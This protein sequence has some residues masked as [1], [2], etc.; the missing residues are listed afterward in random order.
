MS[1]L[2]YTGFSN[3]AP[4]STKR[5]QPVIIS[6]TKRKR[7]VTARNLLARTSRSTSSPSKMVLSFAQFTSLCA[8]PSSA[9]KDDL[10]RHALRA[11][12]ETLVEKKNE[13]DRE[14]DA[15]D[16]DNCT[17]GV[18]SKEGFKII[19]GDEL[20]HY[21]DTLDAPAADAMEVDQ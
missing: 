2:T 12:R 6:T 4:T 11:L 3:K 1:L 18:A 17:V 20:Q 13:K 21:L 8:K 5:I 10:I 14:P 16:T 7:S 9:S 15:L 19:K